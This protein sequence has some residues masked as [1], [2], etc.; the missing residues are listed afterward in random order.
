MDIGY[1]LARNLIFGV[2]IFVDL[3][4]GYASFYQFTEA[5]QSLTSSPGGQPAPNSPQPPPA[6]SS[7]PTTNHRPLLSQTKDQHQ[8]RSSP[9][10]AP[11]QHVAS[12]TSLAAPQSTV[13]SPKPSSS[14]NSPLP[15]S[16]ISH[17]PPTKEDLKRLQQ[18]M[19]ALAS[20]AIVGQK[21]RVSS[22]GKLSTSSGGASRFPVD[23]QVPRGNSHAVIH[24]GRSKPK[25][26]YPAI[27]PTSIEGK[28]KGGAVQTPPLAHGGQSQVAS[29]SPA[30]HAALNQ[31]IKERG[32]NRPV[33]L[34]A[35]VHVPPLY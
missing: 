31:P 18:Q 10:T 13:D 34:Q 2:H 35:E 26:K 19:V 11:N 14:R 29:A 20:Q 27:L 22:P 23:Q 25:H 15:L 7:K 21:Q 33:M 12:T 24:P 28:K 32:G 4:Q 30:I 9:L 17:A 3:Q 1:Q 16:L 8:P 6:H 5:S